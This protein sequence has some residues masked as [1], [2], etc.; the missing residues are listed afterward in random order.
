QVDARIDRAE[1]RL[2]HP[3]GGGPGAGRGHREPAATRIPGHDP[4]HGRTSTSR[5]PPSTLPT[6]GTAMRATVPATGVVIAASI[7][8]ASMC[9]TVPPASTFS[10]T[11]TST[12]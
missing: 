5:S 9:A 1:H 3:V 11:A 6:S 8:I 7:F 4:G 2:A 10:P 12:V